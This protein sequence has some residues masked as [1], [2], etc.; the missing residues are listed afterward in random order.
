M[1]YLATLKISIMK[2]R[3]YI[4]SLLI[5]ILIVSTKISYTQSPGAF[6]YQAV[7]RNSSG[8][9]IADQAV[10]LR[11]TILEG[12]PGGST[13]YSE[14]HQPVTNQFG[15][16]S[17]ELG[18][19][20]PVSG[21]F[22]SISWRNGNHFLQ[23]ELDE[24][25]GSNYQLMGVSPFLSV[26][27]TMWADSAGNVVYSDTSA[28]NELQNLSLIDHELSIENGNSVILP[29]E[30]DDAD[31]DPGNEIQVLYISN[32]T[33][34]LSD[35]GFVKLPPDMV[36]DADA[37]PGNEIQVLFI[38]NDS[39]FLTDGGFV[40]LPPDADP[41]P[42]NEFQ[43][44]EI[45]VDTLFISNGN[46]VVLP[47]GESHWLENGSNIFYNSGK[48]GIGTEEPFESLHVKGN[49]NSD[50]TYMLN[51]NR[52]IAVKSDNNTFIGMNAGLLN[53]TGES[54][55]ALGLNALSSITSGGY[56]TAV[57][58]SAL[59]SNTSG[60]SN[61]ANGSNALKF[62][63]T[64]HSNIAIGV[65][66]LLNNTTKSDLVAIGDS[67]LYSN[68]IGA[69]SAFEAIKNTAIGSK[70]LF[71]NTTGYFNTAI[72]N[73][74]LQ[75][76]TTGY[77]NTANGFQALL[78]N[79]TGSANSAN[80]YGALQTN[81]SGDGNTANGYTALYSNITG[82]YNTAN[83]LWALFHNETGIENTVTGISALFSNTTGSYNVACGTNALYNN[84]TGD[85][86]SAFGPNALTVNTTGYNNTAVGN[87]AGP[88]S[89]NT[90]LSN[91]TALGNGAATTA[92]NQVRVG[93]SSV[94]SISGYV[95]FTS[96]SDRRFKK[97]IKNDI[98]GL[99]F[100]LQ[101]EPVSYQLD[102]EKINDFLGIP[103]SLRND[104]ISRQAA[105]EKEALI[106]T[107]F[108]AQDVEAIAQS[109]GF[110]FSGV[111]APE[112]KNDHYGLRYAE[113][114]VPLVKAVQEQQLTIESLLKVNSELE[115]RIT[116][117]EKNRSK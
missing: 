93:N 82:D 3:F 61:I 12:Y 57:G 64:G 52:V 65:S 33:I 39:I 101:L 13:V 87:W 59:S 1:I 98:P 48:V 71:S 44:L 14:T 100:I 94:T 42:M 110:E 53:S 47:H 113:F 28:I 24:I 9:I 92:S 55:T 106:Q 19:G 115:Q 114:V 26:P 46:Y 40:K 74:A 91:T 73:S 116:N 79:T 5:I 58:E 60:F 31:A 85:A 117:L 67:A 16:V 75:N 96:I 25:G 68:S 83:G 88:S 80:G 76:N 81:S 11:L 37:D 15:L 104:E 43:I 18:F 112:N 27:Y 72:G 2:T 35:G 7:I 102:V 8:D 103:D 17:L 105:K 38:S 49:I 34:F 45:I 50:S 29:D 63:T 90:N 89:G 21:S 20:T 36:E 84:S 111:D 66:A 95:M 56:N 32:D 97:N 108:I 109:I 10:S 23:V 4:S 62:N 30:V 77:E 54:N 78:M 51:G 6:K 69:T 41:D 86:N 22:G 70:A 99:D 107:G